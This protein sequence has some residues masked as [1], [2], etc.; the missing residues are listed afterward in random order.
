MFDAATIGSAIRSTDATFPTT[1]PT[2]LPAPDANPPSPAEML[3]GRGQ[4]VMPPAGIR[5]RNA[6]VICPGLGGPT[7]EREFTYARRLATLGHA[8]LVLSPYA[9]RA[10]AWLPDTLRPIRVGPAMVLADAFAALRWL[11][12]HPEIGPSVPVTVMGFSYGGMVS[13]LA[14]HE[15]VARGFAPD[16]ERF[17]GH[18]AYYGCSVPRLEEPAATGA[19]VLMLFGEKDR[20]VSLPRARMMAE[21][22]RRGGAAEVRMEVLPGAWHAWDGWDERHR[23]VAFSLRD[24]MVTIGRDGVMRDEANGRPVSGHLALLLFLA[25]HARLEGYHMQRNEAVARATD[26]TLFN[27]LDRIASAPAPISDAAGG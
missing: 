9:T 14:A 5:P 11:R 22:L 10:A 26:A 17:A 2:S 13:L 19:P 16:G 3:A 6:I 25:R 4:L 27:F 24:C 20:N 1:S 8:A 21:D 18:V 23:W 12:G 7:E 15:Q